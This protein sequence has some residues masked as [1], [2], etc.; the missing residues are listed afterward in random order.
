MRRRPHTKSGYISL[1]QENFK[2]MV[3][4]SKNEKD[5]ATLVHAHVNYLGHRNIL[6]QS[7]VDMML[8]KALELGHPDTMLETL[9]LHSEL[10]YHPS[11]VVLQRYFEHYKAGPYE[12]LKAFFKTLRGNFLLVKPAGFYPAVIEQASSNKD[13]KTAKFA[14]IDILDYE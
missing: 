8:L 10:I 11:A 2:N 1:P 13:K 12:G 7:Y 14:Y 5:L 3:N 4:V 6:P 9:R